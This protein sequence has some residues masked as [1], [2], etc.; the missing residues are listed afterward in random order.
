[1]C[2]QKTGSACGTSGS[3]ELCR[4]RVP[5][6]RA[7]R[8]Q[9][10]GIGTVD[11]SLSS[12]ES[13]ARRRT[14]KPIERAGRETHAVRISAADGDVSAG[15]NAGQSQTRVSALSRGRIGDEDSTAASDPLE[16]RGSQARGEPAEPTL[17]D[18]FRE[19]L[20]E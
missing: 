5:D 8:L 4:S 2:S 20:R 9:A 12:A 10:A 6:E 18:G 1:M 16:W 3:R 13:G 15:R 19:R 14:A 7:A 11:V 17:V